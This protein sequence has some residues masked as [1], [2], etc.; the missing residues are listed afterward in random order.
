M[1][2]SIKTLFIQYDRT[3]EE[4]FT[5]ANVLLR[6]YRDNIVSRLS[7]YCL[8]I[9]TF[10]FSGCTTVGPDFKR[11]EAPLAK[12]WIEAK[13]PKVKQESVEYSDWWKLFNDPVL[14]NLIKIA[15][16]QN[17]PLQIAGIRILEARAQLG[18]ALG[19]QYPQLQQINGS[20]T[21]QRTSAN[22][23]PG[24]VG[25][26]TFWNAQSSFDVGWELDF[27]GRFRRGV[28]SA[29]ASLIATIADYDGVLVMLTA[30]VASAYVQIRTLEERI[31]LAQANV[32][33]Q[34]RSLKIAD[35]RF[36]N[37]VTTELDVRQAESLLRDTQASIP[38]L[39]TSLRQTKNALSILLGMPPNDLQAILSQPSGIPASPTDVAL[40]MP[41]DLLRRRPDIRRAELQAAAQSALI[42]VAQS[43]LYPRLSL[44]GSIGF[45][46]S[47]AG[48]AKLGNFLNGNSLTYFI[49]PSIQW[50]IFNYGRL[51]NNVRVQDARFEQ[52]IVNYRDTVL[53]AAKEVEDFLVGFLRSQDE[54]GFLGDSVKAAA[55]SVDLALVQYRDGV[56][57]YQRVLDTQRF[58]V[59]AQDLLT[60]TRGSVVLNLIGTYRALGGGW[61][62]RRG[63]EFV[64]NTIKQT[65]RTRTDWGKM[66][67][68]RD[69][70]EKLEPPPA[71]GEQSLFSR[72]DW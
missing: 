25:S 69:L 31:A 66:L 27:W 54:A 59:Q 29:D 3:H 67:S 45:Q 40:G 4:S 49:G 47:D 58:L 46:S 14:N 70:P 32:D 53:R 34:E 22:A 41:A 72:P 50:P 51:K 16:Q 44:I 17:L 33:I 57:D 65:M 56:T 10:I 35:V 13:D 23:P 6:L 71:A 38:R 15:Y 30:D 18:I 68:P 36:H 8:V 39:Q 5:S 43:D 62:I 55:R 52:L 11:P 2:I 63:K 24:V 28:E 37:G 20:T 26:Q 7:I 1:T 42:G 19:S 12:E 9:A 64:P 61:Q 60:Q 21:R 48:N